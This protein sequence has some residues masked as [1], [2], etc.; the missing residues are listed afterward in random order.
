MGLREHARDDGWSQERY[1]SRLRRLDGVGA[2]VL[3]QRVD[4][5]AL[6]AAAGAGR[7]A[8]NSDE[9]IVDEDHVIVGPNDPDEADDAA[10][11][12][13]S[14][15]DDRREVWRARPSSPP[16]SPAWPG[17]ADRLRE[18][19]ARH[20]KALSALGLIAVALCAWAI[21]SART[22]P[23]ES[24]VA[25]T[26]TP[27][28]SEPIATTTPEPP[29][30]PWTIHVLGAVHHPGIVSVPAGSR[31]HDAIAAA[32]GLTDE[33]DPAGL[34]LAAFLTDGVQIIIGT[35]DEP[36]G[37]IRSGADGQAVP[38]GAESGAASTLIDL[39]TATAAQL[40]TLPG[41]GEVT[42]AAILAWREAY[43]PFTQTAELQEVD[44][45]GAKTYERIAPYV[46]V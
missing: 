7:R 36:V 19:G 44:G 39:N 15:D 16:R 20:V 14:S 46:R 1:L 27:Q 25:A 32:G 30:A 31:V 28:W 21:L 6:R 23:I 34:N 40:D 10:E 12:Q 18:V 26:A 45:I 29:A 42:A 5:V 3:A 38:T 17:M 9:A 11:P 4:P 35:V 2:D 43:G 41:V 37:E 13:A 33:A 22:L 24:A 8:W